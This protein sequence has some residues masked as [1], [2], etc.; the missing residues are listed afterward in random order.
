MPRHKENKSIIAN[1]RG[2]Q[3][4][5]VSLPLYSMSRRRVVD[6]LAASRQGAL[7]SILLR[8]LM[9]EFIFALTIISITGCRS[10]TDV[11]SSRLSRVAL[12]LVFV[13]Q[14]SYPDGPDW[15]VHLSQ[16]DSVVPQTTRRIMPTMLHN[17]LTIDSIQHNSTVDSVKLLLHLLVDEIY[18]DYVVSSQIQ[19]SIFRFV[20]SSRIR[21]ESRRSLLAQSRL[22][23]NSHDSLR[24]VI[25][26]HLKTYNRLVR[27]LDVRAVIPEQV[28]EKCSRNYLLTNWIAVSD[29]RYKDSLSI[30][31][32]VP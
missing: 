32:R 4:G 29:Q 15:H 31:E 22:H 30:T 25:L 13:M 7:H 8:D 6:S 19:V 1:A 14:M 9:R 16:L 24:A 3:C 17:H 11:D 5:E 18:A 12:D 2:V 20:L 27:S 28:P 10:V 21:N 23:L 26:T